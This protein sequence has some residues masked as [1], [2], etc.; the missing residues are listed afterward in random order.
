M[1]RARVELP[2]RRDALGAE[3]RSEQ[4][5]RLSIRAATATGARSTDGVRV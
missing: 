1:R 3:R 4:R 5:Q 2:C